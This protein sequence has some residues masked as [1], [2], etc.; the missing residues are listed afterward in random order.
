MTLILSYLRNL[1][2]EPI[3]TFRSMRDAGQPTNDFDLMLHAMSRL[4]DPEPTQQETTTVYAE[5]APEVGQQVP[6]G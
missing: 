4:R 1:L 3:Q 2:A 6:R 5:P